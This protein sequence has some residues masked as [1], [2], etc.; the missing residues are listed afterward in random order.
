MINTNR[1]TA[2]GALMYAVVAWEYETH[3]PLIAARVADDVRRWLS[4]CAMRRATTDGT[5]IH[6]L[7]I[8]ASAA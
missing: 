1:G 6:Y 7:P 8:A 3:L 2:E 5:T 4:I